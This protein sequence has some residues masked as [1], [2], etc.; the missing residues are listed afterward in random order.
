MASICGRS[1]HARQYHS[2]RHGRRSIRTCQFH[3]T[4][5]SRRSIR[6]RQVHSTYYALW[7]EEPTRRSSNLTD[8]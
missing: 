5:H 6:S 8:M 3:S 7:P 4:H 1:I 2:T